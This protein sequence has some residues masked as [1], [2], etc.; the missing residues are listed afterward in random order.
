MLTINKNQIGSVTYFF[1]LS[2]AGQSAGLHWRSCSVSSGWKWRQVLELWPLPQKS[3]QQEP[4]A[5]SHWKLPYSDWSLLLLALL[6]SI[7]NS[8]CAAKAHNCYAQINICVSFS[9]CG[10]AQSGVLHWRTVRLWTWSEWDQIL[11]M[12]RLRKVPDEKMW[13]GET[14]GKLTLGDWPLQLW[15]LLWVSIQNH[16]STSKTHEHCSQIIWNKLDLK[17]THNCASFQCISSKTKFWNTLTARRSVK[18]TRL[19]DWSSGSVEFVRKFWTTRVLLT[20]TLRAF[21]WK[22]THTAA[23]TVLT[24]RGLW[25]KWYLG[26]EE[27]FNVTSTLHTRIKGFLFSVFVE[28]ER[29][30]EF[31]EQKIICEEFDGVKYWK[32]AMCLLNHNR[33]QDLLR[34]IESIHIY[35]DPYH[36]LYCQTSVQFKTKRAL[37]RHLTAFHKGQ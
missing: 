3:Q 24:K 26:R 27:L 6:R 31:L 28:Q 37:Q 1:S 33:K 32:C 12:C 22:Q 21:T 17:T 35:T 23:H 36:C 14:R 11:E 5:S 8:A 10:A 16:A 4:D 20:D 2:G 19:Q 15:V 34:H 30:G 25:T 13:S 29:V 9:L 18:W 7:F